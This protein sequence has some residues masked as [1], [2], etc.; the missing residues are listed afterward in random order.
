MPESS[1]ANSTKQRDSLSTQG[2]WNFARTGL[3][4]TLIFVILCWLHQPIRK[5]ADE[6]PALMNRADT[7]SLGTWTIKMGEAYDYIIPK[8]EKAALNGIDGAEINRLLSLG[9]NGL[10]GCS[11]QGV[12]ADYYLEKKLD[13]SL[14]ARGLIETRD[15][16]SLNKP[17]FSLCY[18]SR[19]TA[20]GESSQDFLVRFIYRFLSNTDGNISKD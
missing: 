5:M 8:F 6:L 2:G 14:S 15:E 9:R 17:P 10:T 3:W 13:A 4:V 12:E 20:L 11:Q 19:P 1:E 18:S 16:P 7:I